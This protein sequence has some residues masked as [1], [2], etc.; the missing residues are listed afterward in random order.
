MFRLSFAVFFAASVFTGSGACSVFKSSNGPSPVPLS[1]QEQYP[2]PAP[3][4]DVISVPSERILFRDAN[5]NDLG[6]FFKIIRLEHSPNSTVLGG[7]TIMSFPPFPRDRCTGYGPACFEATAEIDL[8]DSGGATGANVE[9]F[10]GEVNLQHRVGGPLSLGSGSNI[11]TVSG[12]NFYP[13]GELKNLI[14]KV[15]LRYNN[16][17]PSFGIEGIAVALMNLHNACDDPGM[18][19]ICN[20][21]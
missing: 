14:V 7:L 13:S 18:A 4:S 10:F 16:H 9:F 6:V 5:G 12:M 17:R 8:I 19:S 21:K 3:R 1:F 2:N 11:V 20:L 15:G